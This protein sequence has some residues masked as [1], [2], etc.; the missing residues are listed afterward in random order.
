MSLTDLIKQKRFAPGKGVTEPPPKQGIKRFLFVLSNHFWRLVTLN[1][2]FLLFCV[3]VITIPAAFCGMNRV[4][5]KLVREG[6]CFLWSDFIKEFKGSFLKSLPLGILSAFI[7]FDAYYAL[8]I[9]AAADSTT[10]S[11]I[12]AIGIILI[13]ANVW[14]SGYVFVLLPS[15]ELKNRHIIKNAL[16]LMMTE[17][18]TNIV[19]LGCT[20]LMAFIAIVSFPLSIILLLFIWFSFLQLIICTAVNSPMERRIVEPYERTKNEEAG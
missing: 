1:L 2:L 7:M 9:G 16:I 12:T 19:M 17:W 3:P 4:L 10:G 11:V 18:K 14:F 13:V 5:I 15:L 20:L 6:N 8:S